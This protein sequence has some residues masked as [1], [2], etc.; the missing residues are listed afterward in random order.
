[1][2][3]RKIFMFGPKSEEETGGLKKLQNE[4]LHG[5]YSLPDIIWIFKS[6]SMRWAGHEAHM[7]KKRNIDRVLWGH[8]KKRATLEDARIILNWIFNMLTECG[9][10]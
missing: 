2:V 7:R 9:M 10:D 1:M 4:E 8:L 3:L 6:M 5:L